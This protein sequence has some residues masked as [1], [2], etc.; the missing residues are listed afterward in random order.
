[1]RVLAGPLPLDREAVS[2]QVERDQV[3]AAQRLVGRIGFQPLGDLGQL[4]G[5]LFLGRRL[6]LLPLPVLVPDRS[7]DGRW[8]GSRAKTRTW[9]LPVNRRPVIAGDRGCLRCCQPV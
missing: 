3:L 6:A 1:M 2:G 8:N 5:E 4:G 9:N 7:D